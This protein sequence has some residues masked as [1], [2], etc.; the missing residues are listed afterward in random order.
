[1]RILA[2]ILA[3][4]AVLLSVSGCGS[5]AQPEPSRVVA[6]VVS[7]TTA[8]V[9]QGAT[10]Q[11]TATV[12]G[13]ANANV[14]WSVQE[15]SAGGSITS[16]G[17]YTAPAAAGTFHVI[18]ISQHDSSKSAAAAVVVPAVSVSDVEPGGVTLDQ[19]G[20][21]P[22]T[23]TVSGTVNKGITWSVQ[24]GASGGSI[25]SNGVYT[26]PAAAG[27]FH[28]IAISQA[29]NSKSAAGAVTVPDV[30]IAIS[31]SVVAVART[32]TRQFTAVV[33]GS[34]DKSVTWMM[35]EGTAGGLI[36]SDG[37]YTAPGATGIF[38]LVA[39]S[40][41]DPGKTAIA[42][43]TI[44]EHQ[45][46]P[47]ANML[48]SRRYHAATLLQN[49]DVLV[50]GDGTAE[51][52]DHLG[53][54]FR[55][56]CCMDETRS[57]HTATLLND[58]KV[59]LAGGNDWNYY[60]SD[61]AELY[62]PATATFSW[63]A[64]MVGNAITGRFDHAAT[65]L[66]DGRVLLTGGV[67]YD[68]SLAD[69][70]IVDTAEIYDPVSRI[71]TATGSMTQPRSGHTA[72]LLQDGRVFIGEGLFGDIFD[73]V[74]GTFTPTAAP[75]DASGTQTLL[76]DGRVL[77]TLGDYAELFDPL[78]GTCGTRMSMT[79]T[80]VWHTATRLPDGKV[81]LA[82]GQGEISAELFD[83]VTSTFTVTG[84]MGKERYGHAATL[85]P[86]GRVLITGGSGNNTSELYE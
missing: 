51:I 47:A 19:G 18:A 50:T 32:R 43:V 38:H 29:D 76:A 81:L 45:F 4:L 48:V 75:C 27:T 7:P 24:E 61:D 21:Q 2:V 33:Q 55:Q 42:T 5:G 78:T 72:T 15:G 83:P 84:S 57:G 37:L 66:A 54:T 63:A 8:N 49:G 67:A 52:F 82:G 39:A 62:D 36:G 28:V 53:G 77:V 14:M 3:A 23:A 12:T 1:M 6:V 22:F 58:G 34:V 64:R 60:P 56:A 46:I 40:T 44:V 17:V 59:L 10:Q 26:A 71:F 86:D 65:R 73:P 80:R 35:Q 30:S 20:S 69:Y 31:P 79:T 74:N 9:D 16:N 13:A 25:T 85:L 68:W 11:F 41:A 70:V